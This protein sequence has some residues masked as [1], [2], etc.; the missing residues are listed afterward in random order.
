MELTITTELT[1]CQTCG[2]EF[3]GARCGGWKQNHCDPCI[4]AYE[5]R[6]HAR[7]GHH[8]HGERVSCV[9]EGYQA[10]DIEKLP[11]STRRAAKEKVFTWNLGPIG[12]GLGGRSG[13]GKSFVIFELARRWQEHG[14]KIA[15]V[16]DQDIGRMVR[17]N[18]A[19]RDKLLAHVRRADILVWDDFGLTKMT[20]AVEGTYNEILE[21]VKSR[22]KPI[23][24]T[25]NY[26]GEEIKKRWAGQMQ[27]GTFLED[28]GERIV[29]RFRERCRVVILAEGGSE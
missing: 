20:D 26:G 25:C 24:G 23:F 12:V 27:D 17:E 21:S 7:T 28:R 18:S 13:I 10:F 4:E 3:E 5:K 16:K 9:P 29:R 15:V 8:S 11:E 1:T 14:K 22:G 19:E 2:T 6:M